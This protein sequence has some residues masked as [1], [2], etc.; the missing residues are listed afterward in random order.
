M[1]GLI[2]AVAYGV[3]AGLWLLVLL[4]V[5]GA[6]ALSAPWHACRRVVL[7][8]RWARVA[9]SCGLAVT[10]DR[11]TW[12]GQPAER[13]EYLP[14]ISWGRV[15]PGSRGVRYTV[16]PARGGTLQDVADAAERLAA[17]LHVHRVELE[18]VRADKGYLT[19]VWADPFRAPVAPRKFEP[20]G[21]E[22]SA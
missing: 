4:M 8:A 20:T 15:L 16:R 12:P 5:G 9:R 7:R 1:T 21:A 2:H 19:V 3:A 13:V 14:S 18:R 6:V 10:R 22:V 17:A 11:R